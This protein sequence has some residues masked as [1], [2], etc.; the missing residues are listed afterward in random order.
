MGV[1][2]QLHATATVPPTQETTVGGLHTQSG[3]F[4]ENKSKETNFVKY[5]LNKQ[6]GTLVQYE[7]QRKNSTPGKG[8]RQQPYGNQPAF[9]CVSM[10]EPRCGCWHG[11]EHH[12]SRNVTGRGLCSRAPQRTDQCHLKD[13]LS[14]DH[15]YSANRLQSE[16]HR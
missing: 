3:R 15:T 7:L 13:M 4:G 6:R 10:E 8:V 1:R 14:M 16:T 9:P 2:G 12:F 11:G 5:A